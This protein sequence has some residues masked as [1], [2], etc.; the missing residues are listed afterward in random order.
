MKFLFHRDESTYNATKKDFTFTTSDNLNNPTTLRVED[1]VYRA[2]TQSDHLYPQ[3][4]YLRSNALTAMLKHHHTVEIKS[5]GS[6]Q[7]S[8][9]IAV[10]NQYTT[11][12]YELRGT[13]RFTINPHRT[14]KVFDFQF[15]DGVTPLGDFTGSGTG[16]NAEFQITLQIN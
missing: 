11:G 12:R 10:L 16:V 2:S 14:N 8:N 6:N 15:T 1:V 9:I 3:S 5:N 7:R 13:F 4:I